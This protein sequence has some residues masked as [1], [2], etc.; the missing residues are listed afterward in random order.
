MSSG[1]DADT[2]SVKIAIGVFDGEVIVRWH[3]PLTEI[4][5]DAKNA[6]TIGIHLS[7]AALEAHR[8][9]GD[10]GDLEFIAGDLS[11]VKIKITDAERDAMIAKVAT[12]V[13]TLENK[14]KSPGY[15]A[16]HCVD[17]VLAETAR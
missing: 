10:K 17:M 2:Q 13:K 7:K 16:T 12:I 9:S 8:G 11:Q 5:F 15:I 6:Y 14:K 3:E 4:I 1:S